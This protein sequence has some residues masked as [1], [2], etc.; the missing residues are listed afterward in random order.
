ML[1][2]RISETTGLNFGPEQGREHVIVGVPESL[3]FAETTI[4]KRPQTLATI[5]RSTESLKIEDWQ[6]QAARLDWGKAEAEALVSRAVQRIYVLATIERLQHGFPSAALLERI[7]QRLS[8]V[9]GYSHAK[10]LKDAHLKAEISSPQCHLRF[11][12]TR[13]G[14]API[15]ISESSRTTFDWPTST[16][17][18][19]FRVNPPCYGIDDSAEEI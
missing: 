4:D 5:L 3:V 7:G 9:P 2:D 15:Q 10:M 8:M 1:C 11:G 18:V 17:I 12:S 16:E 19:P 14:S 13:N 6:R